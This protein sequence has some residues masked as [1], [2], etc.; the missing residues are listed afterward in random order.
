MSDAIDV[1]NGQD[2]MAGNI[3]NGLWWHKKGVQLDGQV[4]GPEIIAAVPG[5][6]SPIVKVPLM[7]FGAGD[8]SNKLIPFNQKVGTM[9]VEDSRP[10]GIV[11]AKYVIIQH[12]EVA[13][14][15]DALIKVDGGVKFE[16]A[17]LLYGGRIFW[18]L[19][20]LPDR[21][22]H[23]DGDD[24]D[25]VPYMV[26]KTGH[27]GLTA[28]T[29]APTPV[30]V[31][32]ANTLNMAFSGEKKAQFTIRHTVNAMD[33]IEQARKAFGFNAVEY[34]EDLKSVSQALVKKRMTIA[35]VI[36]ATTA[37]IPST[38]KVDKDDDGNEIVSDKPSKAQ[39]QRDSILG[40]Y[41][42]TDNLQN[43]PHGA[44]RFV[45][46]VAQY[47]DHDRTYRPTVK[48]DADDAKTEA[49]LDGTA[50]KMKQRALTLVMPTATAKPKRG[51]SGRF[52]KAEPVTA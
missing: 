16:S 13:A 20:A 50:F 4:T 22:F 32:C 9:R 24:G 19:A 7:G 8:D 27:D 39:V 14:F 15:A 48:G 37:L 41:R 36:A 5:A 18:M 31:V 12:E 10:L 52:T 26:L 43:L 35:E 30:R 3:R 2:A 44:Y 29:L 38:V 21:A 45:Q 49:I 47:A 40:I 25:I 17:G 28:F 33:Y 42:N 1:V 46:A 6:S 34:V 23:V 51:T 11:G